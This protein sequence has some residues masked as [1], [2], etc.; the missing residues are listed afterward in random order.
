M[1]KDKILTE[2]YGDEE[3]ITIG[4]NL[5]ELILTAH[6]QEDE[7]D[8][9][10]VD[11]KPCSKCD[12]EMYYG[13]PLKDG[14]LNLKLGKAWRCQ[15]CGYSEIRKRWDDTANEQGRPRGKPSSMPDVVMVEINDTVHEQ[16]DECYCTND[17]ICEFCMIDEYEQEDKRVEF[18]QYLSEWNGDEP[19]EREHM[20][21]ADWLEDK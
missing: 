9:R 2:I 21:F 19:D 6:E 4:R 17:T 11:K 16:E 1:N 20:T 7:E 8:I 15:S 13:F 5:M 14:Y 10:R 12:E 18:E 3:V